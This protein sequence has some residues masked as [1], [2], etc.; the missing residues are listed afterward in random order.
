MFGITV[1]MVVLVLVLVLNN[2]VVLML[3]GK[4][5]MGLMRVMLMLVLGILHIAGRREL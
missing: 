3:L 1:L 2:M 5:M 4:G